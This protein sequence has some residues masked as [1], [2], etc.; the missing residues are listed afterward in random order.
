[1]RSRFPFVA[2][3]IAVVS[4]AVFAGAVLPH[5]LLAQ[6]STQDR[7]AQLQAQLNQL[8]K[9]IA[10]NQ[11]MVDRL[12]AQGKSL[13]TE[14]ATLN[15]QIKKAQLQVQATQVA[16]KH[17]DANITIHQK[18]ITS[19]SDKLAAEKD[20][21]ADILRKT[22]QID[23]MTLPEVAFSTENFST[24]LGDLD[25]FA[26]LKKSLGDSYTQITGIKLETEAEKSELEE[27]LTQQQQ[28]AQL[29]L[30]AKQKVQQQQ[31]AKQQLLTE[32]KGQE[33]KYQQIVTTKQKTAA[34]IRA[35]LFGLAGGGGKI[36]LPTAIEYAKTASRITGVRAAFILAILSQE[37]DLGANVGQCYVIDLTTGAG[38][39]KNT[40]TP[41]AN[42]MKS[43]R[44][45][46]P[47]KQI[48]DKLGRDWSTTAVSCPQG[49]GGYGGAMGP[50]QFIP[51]TWIGFESRLKSAL[52]I[53][54]TD[55]W[56]PLHAIVATGLY[57]SAVGGTGGTSAEHT[58]AA[59]YYAG[60]NWATSGQVYANSVM[61]KAAVFQN[62]IDTLGG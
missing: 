23:R 24:L 46:V 57:L 12:A 42:T 9:E 6:T 32:T 60:G 22:D 36:P 34:Q 3:V 11:A 58:A 26:F 15:A 8:E 29:Q 62:D 21:L 51:S 14:V 13:S 30:A 43:P 53:A 48:M 38:K 17:L 20:S 7:R 52:G 47:F 41:F 16:I 28:I 35:E 59:K 27:Q 44:D 10:D 39:G 2:C 61:D 31:L 56:N 18:T 54:A 1:M 49:G 55:P 19:L 45:T 50:T 4:L 25:S 37:S 5:T 33:T 40:G